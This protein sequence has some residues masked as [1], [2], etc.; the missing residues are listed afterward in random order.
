M[1]S[2]KPSVAGA[3]LS[4]LGL[5]R[6]SLANYPLLGRRRLG[7]GLMLLPLGLMVFSQWLPTLA[8]SINL[9]KTLP[10]RWLEVKTTMGEVKIQLIGQPLRTARRGDRITQVRERVSTGRQ[11]ESVLAVD[12]SAAIV[13]LSEGTI[14]EIERL[15]VDAQGGHITVLSVPKGLARVQVRPFTR[16]S[17]RLDIVTPAGVAGVRGTEY[18]VV[19]NPNG[20]ST[21]AT[22]SGTVAASAQGKTELVN[23]NQYSL[24]IPGQPPT[25]PQALAK[26]L[27]LTLIALGVV[28][29][30]ADSKPLQARIVAQVHP[31][32]A[33]W[34]NGEIVDTD[35]K[36]NFDQIVT[37]STDAWV[38]VLVRS[39]LGPEQLYRL[40][41]SPLPLR[42]PTTLG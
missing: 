38:S 15:A 24:I 25:P 26:D 5:S 35:A 40:Y 6:L 9:S 12:Q 7:V 2:N 4:K 39:P 36:G 1:I 33:V 10:T 34:L 27:K 19:V 20:K 28:E 42:T 17:S 16:P 41:V 30:P 37:L 18:G 21:I 3:R 13:R 14:A 31:S 32:N 11:S 22:Q 23:A 8:I 29:T